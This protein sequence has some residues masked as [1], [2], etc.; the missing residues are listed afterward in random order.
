MCAGEEKSQGK[1]GEGIIR[2]TPR[3]GV[4]QVRGRTEEEKK[5]GWTARGDEGEEG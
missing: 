4:R 2:P 5:D 3:G 1:R